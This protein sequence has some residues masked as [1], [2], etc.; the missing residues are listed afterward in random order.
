MHARYLQE[1]LRQR[2]IE[3]A[4][5]AGETPALPVPP[6]T[7]D[8]KSRESSCQRLSQETRSRDQ[9]SE[10]DSQFLTRGFSKTE[11]DS[12]T[13]K[14]ASCLPKGRDLSPESCDR[15]SQRPSLSMKSRESA[16]ETGRRK[17]RSREFGM[18]RVSPVQFSGF[19]SSL[20]GSHKA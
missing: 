3:V 16:F 10:S 14:K 13:R 20:R 8:K 1:E 15:V 4:E 6:P 5:R 2:E 18:G 17:P 19:F 11:R 7:Q 12:K 9:V